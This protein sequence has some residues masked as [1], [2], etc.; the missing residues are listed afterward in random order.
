EIKA[1]ARCGGKLKVIAS[2][3]EP[4]VIAK[5]LAHLERTAPEQHQSEPSGSMAETGVV[6][7]TLAN[8]RS[9]AAV[10]FRIMVVPPGFRDRRPGAAEYI[11]TP[12]PAG[13][14]NTGELR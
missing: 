9:V 1:C 4:E 5:I 3:E 13:I 7:S 11:G 2:I 6:A 10:D 12:W 8:A 14:G